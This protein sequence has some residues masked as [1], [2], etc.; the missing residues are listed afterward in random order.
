MTTVNRAAKSALMI[1]VLTLGSKF[2]GFIREM[3]IAAK[4]GSGMETD[5]FFVALNATSLI[6][7]LLTSA[8]ST[9][10]VPVL[11]EIEEF[12]GKE[13]KVKHTSNMINITLVV[14][15]ILIVLAWISAPL[16]VRLT[17]K[18]FDGEQ[19]I[20]A[21]KLTRI[22][23]PMIL[24]SGIIGSFTGF[25]HSERRHISS[26]AIGFPF[27]AVYIIFLLIFSTKHGIT[28]LMV[29]AVIATASQFLIQ[30]PEA[31]RAGFKYSPIFDPKDIYVKRVLQL[32]IPVL[33]GVAINDLNA[34]VNRTMASDLVDGSIS[35]LNYGNKL[36]ALVQGVFIVAITTVIFPILAKEANQGRIGRMK[37]VMGEGVNL[38]L[39]ITIPAT[40]GIIVLAQPIVEVAFERGEFTAADTIMTKQALI[41]YSLGLVASSMRLLIT[42]VY[43]SLHNTKT[44]MINGAL[45]V[46]FNIL[47][48]LIL[49]RYMAHAGLAFATSISNTTA[50]LILFY[51][52]K[53]RIGSLGTLG[54]V[55]TGVKS[56]AASAPMGVV[57]YL[58]YNGLY[59]FLGNSTIFNLIALVAAV[60]AGALVYLVLCYLFK[61]D[62]V[63]N[64]TDKVLQRLKRK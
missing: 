62:Q 60:A 13:G 44:P 21:V 17:A 2:L 58:V 20:L 64:V 8:I 47:L 4:F 43:Y 12:E 41:F 50:T 54:Y 51:G 32:S 1:S 37:K 16:I 15:V 40:I 61:I 14:A 55:K 23:L 19:F 22:G 11:S 53:K 48:N 30:V 63:R 26:A 33:I 7:T 52:L 42:R 31:K 45:S 34:I 38:V 57:A 27:N 24:F 3:L 29:A 39:L 59:A 18:G 25:L 36:N 10:F 35:A 49:I 9:T 46:G 56:L 28:G 5:T 6:T